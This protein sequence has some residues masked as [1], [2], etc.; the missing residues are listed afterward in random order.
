MTGTPKWVKKVA[1]K[2]KVRLRVLSDIS[3]KAEKSCYECLK[4]S[5]CFA[6]NHRVCLTGEKRGHRGD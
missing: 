2:Q 6:Q 3:V 1:E 5:E 4:Y